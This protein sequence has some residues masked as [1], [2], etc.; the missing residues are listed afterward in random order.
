MDRR[1]F[2]KLLGMVAAGAAAIK[3]NAAPQVHTLEDPAILTPATLQATK[4]EM[5]SDYPE[6]AGLRSST[7][8]VELD[9]SDPWVERLQPGT[10][11]DLEMPIDWRERRVNAGGVWPAQPVYRGRAVVTGV[12]MRPDGI[13]VECVGKGPITRVS[14]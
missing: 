14:G 3:D 12:E 4:L 6:S 8:S 5:H 13:R 9:V 11:V 2:V 7:W 1:F 10:E